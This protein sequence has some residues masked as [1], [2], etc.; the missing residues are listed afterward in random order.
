M[1]KTHEVRNVTL[2]NHSIFNC[3]MIS[4][5]CLLVHCNGG[6]ITTLVSLPRKSGS[7]Y[8]N[9]RNSILADSQDNWFINTVNIF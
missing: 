1:S 7:N 5:I 8:N 9:Q 2:I 3:G 4:V 6:G